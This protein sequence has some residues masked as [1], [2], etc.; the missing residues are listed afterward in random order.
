MAARLGEPSQI[1]DQVLGQFA[2][3]I[4]SISGQV[5]AVPFGRLQLA[6]A[7]IVQACRQLAE[8]DAPAFRDTVALLTVDAFSLAARLAF[9][10]RDDETALALYRDATTIAGRLADR[11]HRAAVRASHAMVSLHAAND[12][13]IAYGIARAA[14]LDAH[15][16]S[17]YRIRARAHAVYAE[18]CART[19]QHRESRTALDRAWQTAD[20]VG[21]QGPDSAFDGDRLNGFEGICALHTGEV[22]RAHDRLSRSVAALDLPRDAVQRGIVSTDLAVATLRL[23]DARACTVLLHKAVD[24]TAQTGGRVSAQRIRQ[25]RRE[26]R[27]WRT[28]TFV[29]DL[30]DHI[31]DTLIGR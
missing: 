20:Q 28:E 14:V 13:N 6:L 29:V 23:G 31:N 19:G 3:D 26:L 8:L 12:P 30:D 9:E 5:G 18:V 21:Q 7:P 25:A 11:R 27:P 1:G 4:A 22:S 16:G 2:A 24:I 15:Q 17:A 10:T